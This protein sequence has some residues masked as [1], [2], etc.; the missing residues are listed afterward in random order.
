MSLAVPDADPAESAPG[1]GVP[2][3]GG[4]LNIDKPSGITSFRV[5]KEARRVLGVKKVGH[6]GTLD[7]MASGV[8]LVVFGR[9]TRQVPSLMLGRKVYRAAIKL[10]LRTD[11][12]DVTGRVLEESAVPVIRRETILETL[13]KFVGT[14][15]Q[16]PPMYSALKHRG[17]KLYEYARRGVTIERPPREIE[18]YSLDLLEVTPD[19]LH[20][21][22]VCSKGT[23]VRTLAEDI[24]R[25]LGLP[26]ALSEL[27]R[28]AVGPYRIEDSIPGSS[29][30]AM[31][32]AD[33]LRRAQAVEPAP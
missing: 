8:L 13:K 33:L 28:E 3:S 12:G 5:V 15:K 14:I 2:I 30:P 4:L 27:V 6:C 7:P 17:K 10:G 1:G 11:T 23:Y 21:R 24:G 26:A 9:A 22:T 31:T 29:L 25:A 16:V 18:I 32:A 20:V 19:T